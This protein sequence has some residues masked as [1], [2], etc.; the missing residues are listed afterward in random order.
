MSSVSKKHKGFILKYITKDNEL[1]TYG[2]GTL[3]EL[4][5]RI[6]TDK[7][8]Y[9][10][11]S[12]DIVFNCFYNRKN[13]GIYNVTFSEF[14]TMFPVEIDNVYKYK[15][16][17]KRKEIYSIEEV[18]PYAINPYEIIENTIRDKDYDGDLIHMDSERYQVFTQ[19]LVC[20]HCGIIGKYFAKETTDFR[21]VE[22]K[23]HFN[24]Y[25]IDKDGKEVLMTKDH[26]IPKSKGGQNHI[27]NYQ[28]MCIHCNE[29]KGN[30][31]ETEVK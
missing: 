26:I 12:D 11:V 20:S 5:R 15:K 9:K 23:Y 19:S 3:E 18:L 22:P 31:L 10:P 24:L 25:A 4:Y 27:S 2:F 8:G 28:T 14:L 29:K 6:V 13:L 30:K 21:N 7:D 17:Y 1:K 16:A